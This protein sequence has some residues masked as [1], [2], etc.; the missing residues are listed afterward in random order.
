MQT[1][2]IANQTT[3]TTLGRHS[4]SHSHFLD[5][6]HLDTSVL[7]DPVPEVGDPGI[8]GGR[9]GGAATAS[10][11]SDTSQH[12]PASVVV[13]THQGA[14][15]VT[16]A[17]SLLAVGEVAHTDV[18]A[19]NA[20]AP[21]RA[22]LTL[23]QHINLSLLQDVWQRAKTIETA[24]SSDVAGVSRIIWGIGGSKVDSLGV[25][26][27]D[28]LRGQTDHRDV[29]GEA[30]GAILGILGCLVTLDTA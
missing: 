25:G 16:I 1:K 12:I 20:G 21:V 13:Q 30:P 26:V 6:G 28:S 5:T 7:L 14:A 11:G 8:D 2:S 22:A 18:V 4:A 17:G 27:E 29:I 23:R 19:H 10:P 3:L 15:A 9:G 24:P